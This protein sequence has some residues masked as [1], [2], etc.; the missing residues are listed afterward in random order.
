METCEAA[1]VIAGARAPVGGFTSATNP[2][3]L[4]IPSNRAIRPQQPSF[5]VGCNQR[6]VVVVDSK[7]AMMRSEIMNSRRP[8]AL[9][10][11]LFCFRVNAPEMKVV[12]DC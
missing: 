6:S 2:C 7:L 11:V 4:D 1:A 5:T 12:S 10:L 3:V 9:R 8:L